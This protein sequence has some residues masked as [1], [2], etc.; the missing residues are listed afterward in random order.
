ME[1]KAEGEEVETKVDLRQ[2]GKQHARSETAELAGAATQQKGLEYR[3]HTNGEGRDY[4]ARLNDEGRDER[5]R[6]GAEGHA[7]PGNGS[8]AI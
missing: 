5:E 6:Q 4:S 3:L 2:R 8:R 7:R 1:T